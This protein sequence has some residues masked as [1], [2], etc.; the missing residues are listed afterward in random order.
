M[1]DDIPQE[2]ETDIHKRME[3]MLEDQKRSQQEQ[4][5]PLPPAIIEDEEKPT[6]PTKKAPAKKK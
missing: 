5:Y 6:K 4:Y 3:A 2:N 1:A